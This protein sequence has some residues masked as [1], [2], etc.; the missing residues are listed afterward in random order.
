MLSQLD[1][2]QKKFSTAYDIFKEKLIHGLFIILFRVVDF[3]LDLCIDSKVLLNCFRLPRHS[4]V[5]FS[6]I[7]SFTEYMICSHYLLPSF[8]VKYCLRLRGVVIYFRYSFFIR[9]FHFHSIHWIDS[10]ENFC[11][12]SIY[13]I[14]NI[15]V[16]YSPFYYLLYMYIYLDAPT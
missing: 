3:V 5:G 14:C 13:Y 15:S 10:N 9:W 2:V 4:L 8:Q 12:P 16:L 6:Y 7:S 1:D 11:F